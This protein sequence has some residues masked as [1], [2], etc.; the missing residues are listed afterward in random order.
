MKQFNQIGKYTKKEDFLN[1]KVGKTF[2]TP[3]NKSYVFNYRKQGNIYIFI[4]DYKGKK[5]QLT[6][7]DFNKIPIDTLIET[8]DKEIKKIC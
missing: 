7:S 2:I 5:M 1:G 4:I 8:M 3:Q 6:E